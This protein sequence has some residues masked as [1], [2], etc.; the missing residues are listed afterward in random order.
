MTIKFLNDRMTILK[1]SRNTL[2][3]KSGILELELAN[4]FDKSQ[5]LYFMDYLKILGALEIRPYLVTK[6]DDDTEMGYINFN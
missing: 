4:F 6:E 3:E 1:M 5:D 2:S